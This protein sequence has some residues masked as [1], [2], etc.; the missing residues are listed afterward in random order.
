LVA[1]D[2]SHAKHPGKEFL[3]AREI[4][5]AIEL[6]LADKPLKR[7]V[8]NLE[9]R[10]ELKLRN[11]GVRRFSFNLQLTPKQ[12]V[13]LQRVLE[14]IEPL[15]PTAPFPSDIATEAGIPL[16]AAEEILRLG[17]SAGRL[18][19]LGDHL[20]YSKKQLQ[21]VLDQ[22]KLAFL[23]TEFTVAQARDVLNSSRRFTHP[24]L[25]HLEKLGY[26]EKNGEFRKFTSEGHELLLLP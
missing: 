25:E 8:K 1:L 4:A 26:L 24:L 5:T 15:G 13:L 18:T 19:Q 10:G 17:V 14:V 6:N 3:E 16:Q 2:E 11:S 23:N 22:L 20:F 12:E 21:A 9:N 7:F